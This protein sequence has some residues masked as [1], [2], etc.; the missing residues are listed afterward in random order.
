MVLDDRSGEPVPAANVRLSDVD[1]RVIKEVETGPMVVL[2]LSFK[3]GVLLQSG[4]PCYSITHG[5]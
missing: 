1:G 2:E 3:Q 5:R 4:K